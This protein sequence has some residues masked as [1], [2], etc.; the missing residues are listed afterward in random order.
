M[1]D[2]EKLEKKY[3]KDGLKIN[4][5]EEYS[6]DLY[7]EMVPTAFAWKTPD[8]QGNRIKEIENMVNESNNNKGKDKDKDGRPD[9]II[10]E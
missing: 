3:G 4:N 7:P 5:D 9:Y 6:M 8:E 10:L 2:K 1:N